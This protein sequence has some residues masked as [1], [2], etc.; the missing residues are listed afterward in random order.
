[1]LAKFYFLIV[2]CYTGVFKDHT[3]DWGNFCMSDIYMHLS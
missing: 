1:M 2:S 3:Y